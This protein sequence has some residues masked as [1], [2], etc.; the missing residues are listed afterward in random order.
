M[1]TILSILLLLSMFMLTTLTTPKAEA[2]SG[3]G[4]S[5]FSAE[6]VYDFSIHGGANGAISLVNPANKLPLG[7]YVLSGEYVV[8]T[9][10]NSS[11]GATVALG[12][13]TDTDHYL[14]ATAYGDSAFTADTVKVIATGVPQIAS[15]TN[16]RS[17]VLL[18]NSG[19]L[20]AGKVKF[21]LHGYMPKQ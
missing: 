9:A 4:G 16:I 15:T 19:T 2:L 3:V 5:T 17:P 11:N 21:I 6:Y 8:L 14:A 1:K 20:T 18:I 7:G 13:A 12:D 10:L